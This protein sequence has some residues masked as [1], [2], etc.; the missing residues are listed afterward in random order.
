MIMI[1]NIL[2]INDYI[3]QL[4]APGFIFGRSISPGLIPKGGW[5]HLR[6]VTARLVF[7]GDIDDLIQ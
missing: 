5:Q 4:H 1:K 7:R 6:A 2:K 3:C